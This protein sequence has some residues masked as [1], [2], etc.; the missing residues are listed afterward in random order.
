MLQINFNGKTIAELFEDKFFKET[1]S[2]DEFEY[3]GDVQTA[4]IIA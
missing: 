2:L 1:F 4:A 3:T